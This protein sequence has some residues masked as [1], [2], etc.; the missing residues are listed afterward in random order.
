MTVYLPSIPRATLF[1]YES[2]SCTLSLRLTN[3]YAILYPSMLD[4]SCRSSI[5]IL[6][7]SDLRPKFE[8]N[9][10]KRLNFPFWKAALCKVL[11][12]VCSGPGREDQRRIFG[13]VAVYMGS[14]YLDFV[15]S[16]TQSNCSIVLPCRRFGLCKLIGLRLHS[17]KL[18]EFC[19]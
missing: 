11:V 15:H 17:I 7:T 14:G 9:A 18:T 5:N 16:I 2:C 10:A 13:F 12:V 8:Y 4:G 19:R 3:I 6:T 1:R